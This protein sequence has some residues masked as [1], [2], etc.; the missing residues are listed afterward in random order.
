MNEST[1]AVFRRIEFSRDPDGPASIELKTGDGIVR[2][3]QQPCDDF[4]FK[5]M[6]RELLAQTGVRIMNPRYLD[7]AFFRAEFLLCCLHSAWK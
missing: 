5:I 4:D 3:S 2:Y 6:Q 1:T 7:Y